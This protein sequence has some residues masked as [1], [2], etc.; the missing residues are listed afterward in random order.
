M[1]DPC[2]TKSTNQFSG[3]VFFRNSLVIRQ[4][5]SCT[6]RKVAFSTYNAKDTFTNEVK[7]TFIFSGDALKTNTSTGGIAGVTPSSCKVSTDCAALPNG[8]NTCKAGDA[9]TGMVCV[10]QCNTGF[11]LSDDKKTCAP[12]TCNEDKDCS[13]LPN[14]SNLC[15]TGNGYTGKMCV[16]ACNTGFTLSDD[17]KTCNPKLPPPPNP[18]CNSDSDCPKLT[19]GSNTCTSTPAYAGKTCVPACN[20]GF[21]LSDDKKTCKPNVVPPPNKNCKTATDCPPLTNG[22]YECKADPAMAYN[23]DAYANTVCV[24][25]CKGGFTLSADKTAC[26]PTEAPQPQVNFNIVNKNY[27]AD[28]GSLTFSVIPDNAIVQ[29]VTDL[30]TPIAATTSYKASYLPGTSSPNSFNYKSTLTCTKGKTF[31]AVLGGTATLCN[32]GLSGKEC[33]SPATTIPNYNDVKDKL[34]RQ[35]QFTVTLTITENCDAQIDITSNVVSAVIVDSTGAATLSNNAPWTLILNSP[36]LQRGGYYIKV[37]T[38]TIA[39]DYGAALPL[40]ASCLKLINTTPGTTNYGLKPAPIST[41]SYQDAKEIKCDAAANSVQFLIPNSY[42]QVNYA[43]NFDLEFDTAAFAKRDDAAV[44]PLTGS[45]TAVATVDGS[46]GS[47]A[48][49]TL[50]GAAAMLAG[51]AVVF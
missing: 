43:F 40:A 41:N 12:K 10:P 11:T 25:S 30:A 7:L 42:T 38:G 37:L 22:S 51:L 32:Y 2:F 9:Y 46:L 15:K 19:D 29:L 5:N 14:G 18:S 47:G 39:A 44:G 17:K 8:S 26:N 24:P 28:T 3:L 34:T 36:F 48:L 20:A 1:W 23:K 35:Q 45:V 13:A 31:S 50:A 27:D 21:T 4:I 6:S 33:Q 49:R 16:P